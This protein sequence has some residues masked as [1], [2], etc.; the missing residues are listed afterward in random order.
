MSVPDKWRDK[1]NTLKV[2]ISA[3]GKDQYRMILMMFGVKTK[4]IRTVLLI[5]GAAKN[6]IRFL[7]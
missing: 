5:L 1:H 4:G 2:L 7:I 6:W 3:L